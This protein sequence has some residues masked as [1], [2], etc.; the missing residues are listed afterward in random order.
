[1]AHDFDMVFCAARP[2]SATPRVYE[3]NLTGCSGTYGNCTLQ[4]TDYGTSCAPGV[5]SPSVNC[6]GTIAAS[7]HHVWCDAYC[8]G[9][10]GAGSNPQ[11]TSVAMACWNVSGVCPG[12][13]PPLF[14]YFSSTGQYSS[15]G[16]Q[17]TSSINYEVGKG[18]ARIAQPGQ[19][20]SWTWSTTGA[21]TT[22]R[23]I[24]A[25]SSSWCST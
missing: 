15:T 19:R 20:F 24:S 25:R 6:T 13:T 5:G 4:V 14:E 2:G 1:V 21:A 9:T 16:T 18:G 22:Q 7:V 12:H 8:Q 11:S 3:I 17:D 23:V 10:T